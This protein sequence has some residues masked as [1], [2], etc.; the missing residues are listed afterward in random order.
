MNPDFHHRVV[1]VPRVGKHHDPGR[2]DAV[3]LPRAPVP[4]RGEA[5]SASLHPLDRSLIAG[6][7][8]V[9]AVGRPGRLRQLVIA[10][11]VR[12][13]GLPRIERNDI[14]DCTYSPRTTPATTQ[15]PARAAAH[16]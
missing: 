14:H 11:E 7:D 13:A 8:R 6:L 15:L 5:S 10:R 4:G 9:R 3:V 12:L 1:R 2:D 16:R